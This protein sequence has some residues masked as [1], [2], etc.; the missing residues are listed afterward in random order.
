MILMTA[1]TGGAAGRVFREPTISVVTTDFNIAETKEH[2]TVL[3]DRYHLDPDDVADTLA[4][5]PLRVYR[6]GE[7]ESHIAEAR[8]QIEKKDPKDVALLALALKLGID[9][10]SQDPH[11]DNLTVKRLTTGRILKSLGQ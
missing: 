11:Y 8:A 5:L 2:V 3:I 1:A 9:I 7:Y 4:A 10:W 6:W